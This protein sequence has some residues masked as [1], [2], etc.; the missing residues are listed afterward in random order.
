[1]HNPLKIR[2]TRRARFSVHV[3]RR[4]MVFWGG[5]V[6]VGFVAVFFSI[7]SEYANR[8][9]QWMLEYSPILPLFITPLGLALVV[10]ITRRFFPG[11]QGSG[12]PQSIAAIAM[13]NDDDRKKVLS[14]RIAFGKIALTL[15]ALLV[16]ASV[17]R[18]GPTVQIGSAIMYSLSR[19]ARFSRLEVERGLI[20]AGGAAGIA[21]A[22]NTPLAGIV[23]AI[24]EMSRSFEERTSGNT[25]TA[26][27]IAGVISLG[28]MG[29]YSYFGHTSISLPLN[30]SW[31]AAIICGVAGGVAGG[32]FSLTVISFT[33]KGLPGRV[34]DIIKNS[35]VLFAGICGLLLA[36][37]GL[38]SGGHTYGT[39]YSEAKGIIE[40]TSNLPYSYGI[41]KMLATIVS[42]LSGIPG[43]IFAPCLSIGAGFGVNLAGIM[44]FAPVG[45]VV[46]LGMVAFFSGVVQAP[47]TAFVIVMEM[48]DNHTMILPLMASSFIAYAVS[49]RICPKPLYKTM[50]EGFISRIEQQSVG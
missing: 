33:T 20:L 32:I 15:S 22:F 42:F 19:F 44:P 2:L 34:G 8:L 37:I 36:L 13:T 30:L 21:A 31:L 24:E 35:P 47:I 41:L 40:G 17:G 1:M 50:A 46:I 9:F 49:S 10:Y 27:V 3:W 38:A 5:A 11:S 16:G 4:R 45:A 25:M 28:F 18:E 14:L 7:S 48:T 23:F 43:G 26:V 6:A 12:I 29:N 39:G